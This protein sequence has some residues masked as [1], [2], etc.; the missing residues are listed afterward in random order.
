M[1]LLMQAKISLY[2]LISGPE[3]YLKINADSLNLSNYSFSNIHPLDSNV[4]E[5]LFKI[6]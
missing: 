2:I 6:S 3:A 1:K 4:N 5:I